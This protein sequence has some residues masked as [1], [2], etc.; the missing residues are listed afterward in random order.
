MKNLKRGMQTK[1][2]Q[3]LSGRFGLQTTMEQYV[4]VRD[5]PM[6]NAV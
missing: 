1:V 5:A 2:L 3:N 4:Y 6:V